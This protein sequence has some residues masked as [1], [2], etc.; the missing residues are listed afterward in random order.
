MGRCGFD[1][2]PETSKPL[3]VRPLMHDLIGPNAIGYLTQWKSSG[4]LIRKCRFDSCDPTLSLV[5]NI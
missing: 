3:L 5:R 1:S 2:R 4:L